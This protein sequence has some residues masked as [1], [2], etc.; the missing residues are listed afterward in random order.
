MPTVSN[1][2]VGSGL[3][4]SAICIVTRVTLLMIR[5]YN[6]VILVSVGQPWSV[7]VLGALVS[8]CNCK[9]IVLE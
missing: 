3:V 2:G 5:A 9:G 6:P 8:V 4:D 1:P 7:C